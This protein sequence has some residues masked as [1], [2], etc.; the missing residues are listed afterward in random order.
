LPIQHTQSVRAQLHHDILC[1]IIRHIYS[2]H[3][4]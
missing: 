1:V 4:C 3:S 2:D